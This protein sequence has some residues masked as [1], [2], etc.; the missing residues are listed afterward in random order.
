MLEHGADPN[1]G[2]TVFRALIGEKKN[3]L[4]VVQLLEKHG[5]DLH[6]VFENELSKEHEPM[7]ALSM[8]IACGKQDVAEYLRSKG[9]VLPV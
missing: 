9:V 8:A 2:R 4:E 5:V 3:S 7:N 1:H 6:R